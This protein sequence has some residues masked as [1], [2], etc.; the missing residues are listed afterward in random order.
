MVS[1]YRVRLLT[2]GGG[3]GGGGGGWLGHKVI[4]PVQS[5]PLLVWAVVLSAPDSVNYQ[6]ETGVRRQEPGDRSQETLEIR[7]I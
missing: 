3:G 2:Q 1:M 6:E 7:E 4:C 5:S